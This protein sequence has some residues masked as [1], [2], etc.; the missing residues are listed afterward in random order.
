M[1]CCQTGKIRMEK[2]RETKAATA[3]GLAARRQRM[4]TKP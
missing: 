3:A 4:T 2:L 1:P